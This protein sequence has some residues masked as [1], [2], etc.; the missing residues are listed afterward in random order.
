MVLAALVAV[1][2]ALAGTLVYAIAF[3]DAAR[4]DISW[5]VAGYE[6][7]DPDQLRVTIVVEK[8]PE[9][10]ARCQV[11]AFTER[12]R[13]AGRLDGILVG[14]RRDGSR[15]NRL[16][17]VVPTEKAATRAQISQCVLLD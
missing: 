15:V 14:P 6:V 4:A 2:L 1:G 7:G 10:T 16:T 12:D 8:P 3:H 11:A 5:Q 13:S 9:A 17:I